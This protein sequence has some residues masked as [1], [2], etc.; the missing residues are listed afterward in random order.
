MTL[1]VTTKV[2]KPLLGTKGMTYAKV[3]LLSHLVVNDSRDR[4]VVAYTVGG[5]RQRCAPRPR[6]VCDHLY[7]AGRLITGAPDNTHSCGL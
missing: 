2:S 7:H 5:T 3:S 4:L 1:I 6:L